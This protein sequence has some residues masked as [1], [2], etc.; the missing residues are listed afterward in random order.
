MILNAIK[1]LK[2]KILPFIKNLKPTNSTV[3]LTVIYSSLIFV[4][5]R[6]TGLPDYNTLRKYHGLPKVTSWREINPKLYAVHPELFDQ[7]TFK[8]H[9]QTFAVLKCRNVQ[10]TAQF[11]AKR[12]G[13]TWKTDRHIQ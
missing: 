2:I 13:T 9:L 8:R 4:L 12:L 5:G 3:R 11:W 7:V 10:H 6:D 1:I